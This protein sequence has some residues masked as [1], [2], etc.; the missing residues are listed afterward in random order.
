LQPAEAILDSASELFFFLKFCIFY[1]V[2]VLNLIK[3]GV[4]NVW[5]TALIQFLLHSSTHIELCEL[6]YQSI[7]K[8][9]VLGGG[10]PPLG[11]LQ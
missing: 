3:M 4:I 11:E 5:P 9:A 6:P 2:C 7:P 8:N 10:N 1:F